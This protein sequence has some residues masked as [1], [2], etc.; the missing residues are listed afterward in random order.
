MITGTQQIG[1]LKTNNPN[2]Q[3]LQINIRSGPSLNSN[4]KLTKPAGTRV[5]ILEKNQ[6]SGDRYS[7]YRIRYGD[8]TNDIGWVRED[9]INIVPNPNPSESDTR[10]F[11]ETQSRQV[12][13]YGG[14]QSYMNVYVK[15]TDSTDL[16]RATAV[17]IPKSDNYQPWISYIALKDKNVYQVRFIPLTQTQSGEA[18]L[19]IGDSNNGRI[20]WQE[21]GFS[22]QGYEYNRL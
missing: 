5:S 18:E 4:V 7:W 11:F 19:I 12:R 10:L 16:L 3:N 14:E 8:G 15:A 1:I 21:K 13:I 6:P 9:V 17:R 20:S 22:I 2:N